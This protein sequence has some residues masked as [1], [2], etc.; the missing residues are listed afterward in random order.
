VFYP[1]LLEVALEKLVIFGAS[2]FSEI[3]NSYFTKSKY[4]VIAHLVDADYV[5][6]DLNVILGVP[7]YSIES[8]EGKNAL[9]LATHFYVAA[10]YTKLNRIRTDKFN[11]FKSLGLKPAS[12]VSPHSFVDESVILGEHVFIFE[13]NVLQYG[14]TIGD[15]CVLWSGNHIGHHSTI[16]ENVFISSHVVVCGHVTVGRNSFLGVNSSIYNNVELGADNWLSPGSIIEKST[17]ENSLYKAKGA[18]LHSST[19]LRF[20]KLETN[21]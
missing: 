9:Q 21:Q 13:N 18:E 8:L 15:N 6:D 11:F 14:V 12:Y 20:F 1:I 5:R 3:A 17:L 2:S 10:T 16:Q 7:V 4:E 19:P